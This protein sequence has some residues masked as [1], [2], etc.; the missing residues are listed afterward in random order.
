MDTNDNAEFR[1]QLNK[2]TKQK[3]K[4][5]P[6]AI[7]SKR[8]GGFR[9]VIVVCFIKGQVRAW[10]TFCIIGRERESRITNKTKSILVFFGKWSVTPP[11]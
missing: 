1:H 9:K 11:P 3:I 5:N 2:L 10:F 8:V 4:R 6:K 7:H